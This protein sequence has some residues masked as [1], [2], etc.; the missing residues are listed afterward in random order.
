VSTV[1][2][3]LAEFP[4]LSTRRLVLRRIDPEAD[5]EAL[6]TIFSDPET[7]RYYGA[8]PVA[9][10]AHARRLA[11]YFHDGFLAKSSIRWGIARREDR[12]LI[13]TCGYNRWAERARIGYIGYDL[14][15][16]AWGQGIGTEAIRAMVE[17]GFSLLELNRIQ[18]EV[19]PGNTA[20]EALLRRLGFRE[21]GLLREGIVSMGRHCDLKVFGLLRREYL[22]II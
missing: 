2:E 5:A 7:M 14:A 8:D 16:Q 6:F 1:A 9:D 17:L 15:R 22:N 21:E 3:A 13:G 18:A 4:E 12:E 11:L 10:R 19:I 20:S